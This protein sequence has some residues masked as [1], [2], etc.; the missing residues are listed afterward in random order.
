[1]WIDY[2][3]R[4]HRVYW[5]THNESGPKRAFEPF[6]TR[7]QAK[8]FI[9]LSQASTLSGA[10]A[11]VRDPSPDALMRLLGR[12]PTPVPAQPSVAELSV[13]G[14]TIA[15]SLDSSQWSLPATQRWSRHTTC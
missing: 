2:R 15:A 14:S 13:T 7:A 10:V 6:A 5:R 12:E 8:A 3:G 9:A 1:M 11:Y 4:Q